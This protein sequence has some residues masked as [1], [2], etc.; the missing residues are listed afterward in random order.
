M[1]IGE[2]RV[3]FLRHGLP[4]GDKCLRGHTDF[5][6]TEVGFA[7]MEHAASS[8]KELDVIVTSPLQRCATFAHQLRSSLILRLW[9]SRYGKR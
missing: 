6:L 5:A 8:L 9:K 2:T 7:Q 4:E 1:T 3:D